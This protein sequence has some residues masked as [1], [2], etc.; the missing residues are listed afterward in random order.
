[1][2]RPQYWYIKNL[3][4][5]KSTCTTALIPKQVARKVLFPSCLIKHIAF[6]AN[7]YDL[8]EESPKIKQVVKENGYEET[9][10]KPKPQISKRKRS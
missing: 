1:M 2:E 6:I 8:T 9:S 10:N 5:L 7:K 4:I 3:R